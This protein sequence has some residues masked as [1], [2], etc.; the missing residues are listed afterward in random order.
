MTK[1]D[2]SVQQKITIDLP[3]SVAE[4]VY[5]N[6]VTIAHS[7]S[8][9]VLDFIRYMP[10]LP[11]ARVKARVVVTPEHAKRLL[12]IF[13]ENIR[14]YEETFGNIKEVTASEP[15]PLSFGGGSM[16]EA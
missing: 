8:E 1:Q 12:A 5:S 2:Q 7:S 13:E 15:Y 6:L 3:E 11:K 10:G 4:G 9:F 14:K 16:G